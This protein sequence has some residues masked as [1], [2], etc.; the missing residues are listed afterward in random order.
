MRNNCMQDKQD[1]LQ[2]HWQNLQDKLNKGL[3]EKHNT[4]AEHL[5]QK[6]Q[7]FDLKKAKKAKILVLLVWIE[8]M[9]IL[10]RKM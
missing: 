5:E 1:W 10:K 4:A 6:S 7:K 2:N 9:H 8:T 3:E